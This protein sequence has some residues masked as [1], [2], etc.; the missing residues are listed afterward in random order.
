MK[1]T[2][3]TAKGDEV[4]MTGD[5]WDFKGGFF[6]VYTAT[7]DEGETINGYPAANARGFTV[8]NSKERV[9]PEPKKK[10]V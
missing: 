7:K 1:L 6:M 9:E 5:E 2:I 10:T 8:S 4:I 3:L